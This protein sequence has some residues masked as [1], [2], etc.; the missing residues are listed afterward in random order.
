MKNSITGNKKNIGVPHQKLVSMY[1]PNFTQL[2]VKQSLPTFKNQYTGLYEPNVSALHN[3]KNGSHLAR[4]HSG[5][6]VL[7]KKNPK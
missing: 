3:Q 4:P 2:N 7:H 1:V 5:A 6:G